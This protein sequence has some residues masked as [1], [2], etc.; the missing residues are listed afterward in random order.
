M[1]RLVLNQNN[2]YAAFTMKDVSWNSTAYNGV[3]FKIPFDTSTFSDW[4]DAHATMHSDPN[5]LY[6]WPANLP[7]STFLFAAA[8]TS[9]SSSTTAHLIFKDLIA[10]VGYRSSQFSFATNRTT[11]NCSP[12]PAYVTSTL[13]DKIVLIRSSPNYTFTVDM[14]QDE[15]AEFKVEVWL[16]DDGELTS[17]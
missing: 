10:E 7:D 14:I 8:P 3:I 6:T 17:R 11:E 5:S 16:G 13:P 9:I 4:Y 12:S 2:W 15:G 1:A